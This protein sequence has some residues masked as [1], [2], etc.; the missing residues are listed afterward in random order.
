MRWTSL[1][2]VLVVAACGASPPPRG[3]WCGGGEP[4]PAPDVSTPYLG[5]IEQRLLNAGT[6]SLRAQITAM[7]AAVGSVEGT[8]DLEDT[9]ARWQIE[10]VLDGAAVAIAGSST[11]LVGAR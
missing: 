11:D 10:G 7:G 4:A 9:T 6:V 1:A 8:L 5:E 2:I 3:S